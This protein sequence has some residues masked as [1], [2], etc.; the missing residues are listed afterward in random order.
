MLFIMW[1]QDLAI[2]NSVEVAITLVGL[3]RNVK[4]SKI[5]RNIPDFGL[6]SM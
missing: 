4:V 2:V 1:S 5:P 3:I 6:C